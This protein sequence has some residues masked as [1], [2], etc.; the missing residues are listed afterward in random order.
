[1]TRRTPRRWK[2]GNEMAYRTRK[3]SR[4]SYTRRAPA[5]RPAARRR[6]PARRAAAR[7][8]PSRSQTV[9]IVVEHVGG[10][11]MEPMRLMGTK[12]SPAAKRKAKF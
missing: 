3:S 5:R 9:R 6:A 4:A 10:S 7:R 1:M 12:V 2:D 8:A 11:S